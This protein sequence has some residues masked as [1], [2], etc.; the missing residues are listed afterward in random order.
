MIT[1]PGIYVMPP[2]EYHADPCPEPSLSRS[3][4]MALTRQSP[5]KAHWMHPRLGIGEQNDTP[6]RAMDDGSIIHS[7]LLGI[8]ATMR[9]LTSVYG[10][11][12]ELAGKP[13]KDFATKAAKDE[14]EAIRKAGGI[15][16]LAH[17][18]PFL[19]NCANTLES[20]IR[21]HPDARGFFH[22]GQSEAVVVWCEDGV[23]LRCMVDRLPDDPYRPPFDLK[24]TDMSA[25][26][27]GWEWRLRTEYAFQDA[28][29]RRGIAAVRGIEP[30]PMRFLVGELD[31]PH[32]L[33]VMAAAPSLAALAEAEVERAIRIWKRCMTSGEWPGLA[34]QT[35]WIEATSWQIT[36]ADEAA[37]RAEMMENAL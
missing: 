3:I 2:E 30:E 7:A 24:L 12:H 29:Y 20:M 1:A 27:D 16:V 33:A 31:A 4:A 34:R 8:G 5:R 19:T 25:A 6:S 26:P 32:D 28:F 21:V 23:W 18:V 37:L 17:R 15:P 22:P 10:P 11:K 35:A 14:R 36:Q 13:V 9:P